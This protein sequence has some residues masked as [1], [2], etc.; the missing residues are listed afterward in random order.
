MKK[1]QVI[2]GRREPCTNEGEEVSLNT[3]IDM[4]CFRCICQNGFVECETE[5]CPAVDDCYALVKKPAGGCCDTC[6]ECLYKGDIY[7]SGAEWSDPD[8]PCSHFKCVA[9]V[10]TE[11]NF[12]CY[13]PCS[14]PSPPRPGQCCPTCLGC[15][16]N[17]QNVFEEREV[18]LSE[19]PCVKCECN[20]KRLSCVK[21]A[22]PVLQCPPSL[23]WTPP[24]QCCKKCTKNIPYMQPTKG[25]CILTGKYYQSLQERKIYPD[26]CSTCTCFNESSVCMKKTCPVLECSSDYQ[27]TT[28]GECC[29]HCPPIVTEFVGS[30]CTH[31]GITYQNNETWN[32]GPCQSCECRS[33]EIR[34]AQT[35]CPQLKCR[36]NEN[37][38]AKEGQCCAKCV[39]TPGVCTVFGDP[40]YKTFDGKF[41][42]FQ[43]ACKYQLTADCVDHT[44][45]IRVTNDVRMTKFST[46][47][48]TKTL[49]L[50]MANIKINLGQK[51]RVKVNG[52]RVEVP[53]VIN[54]VV[55]IK[56]GRDDEIIVDTHLGVKLIWD[57]YNFL[58]VE[59]P[60]RYK[61]RLCGLCGNYNNIWRDDLTSRSGINM[62]DTEVKKFADTWR[63]GGLR[64][65]AR[66]PHE[67]HHIQKP[68]HCVNK[69]KKILAKCN[70]L[71][72][73]NY[74]G[75]C[76][77]RVN[78][79]KYHDFC[80]MD[81]CDCP[82][83]MCYCESF[84]AYAHECERNGV[85]LPRWREEA[86]CKLSN[87]Y[88][89][90]S[91]QKQEKPIQ[92]KRHRN[93]WKNQQQQ[94]DKQHKQPE[95]LY[96][97][98]IPKPHVVHAPSFSAPPPPLL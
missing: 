86:K 70:E 71:K 79:D 88:S 40:H 38:V 36:P 43:G 23:Q 84:T 73:Q 51:L 31:K 81:M 87:L 21:K 12:Q 15:H 5:S 17:G 24:G 22:C 9:G 85:R 8:D 11:S 41:F 94:L 50:K 33:G 7:V 46:K 96:R 77:S 53:F 62:S 64:A 93:R 83:H 1:V 68:Q 47:T 55:N 37:L 80:K 72:L 25:G 95:L 20:G 91:V 28:P 35:Q 67:I 90:K 92:N 74:F 60:V 75:N 14:N 6:K 3:N 18:T 58:Q 78:P 16:L 57:G 97:Q 45:S 63:V 39:E 48:R 32:L 4:R 44:F 42:S 29:P 2:P 34:C 76:N 56:K 89:N 66:K 49:T 69:H 98:H 61:N 59:A 27:Q 82:S 30:T 54:K 13:T 65:C 52:T 10:V 26:S 19:D